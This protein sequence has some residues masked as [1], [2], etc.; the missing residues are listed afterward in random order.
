VDPRLQR[1]LGAWN[2]LVFATWSVGPFLAVGDVLWARGWAHLLLLPACLTG[3]RAYAGRRNPEL[4]RRRRRIGAGTKI[5]DLWWN[6]L[7]WPLMAGI[8]VG[9]GLDARRHPPLPGWTWAAGAAL[10]VAGIALSAAAFAANP[11]FEGTVRIQTEVGQHPVD[12]GPYGWIRHPGYA[13]LVL[14]ALA[15]PLLLGSARAFLPAAT[16]ATW[17]VFRTALEDRTLRH[18]LP[19]YLEYA[20]R[21]RWHLLPGVW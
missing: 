21:V 2:A 15:T 20:G 1:L 14:W 7:F 9:A 3:H 10:L 4:L 19:G 16:A 18:E 13:G 8:A 11:F 17:V 6:V 12:A 5:W